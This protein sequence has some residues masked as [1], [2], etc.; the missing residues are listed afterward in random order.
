MATIAIGKV[1][2]LVLPRTFCCLL[3]NKCYYLTIYLFIYYLFI[4]IIYYLFIFYVF[5]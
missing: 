2:K 4:I 5:N 1:G 3:G